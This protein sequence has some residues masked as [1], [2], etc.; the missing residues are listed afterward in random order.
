MAVQRQRVEEIQIFGQKRSDFVKLIQVHQSAGFEHQRRT[1]HGVVLLRA[2]D[3]VSGRTGH[4]RR[5]QHPGILFHSRGNGYVRI[6]LVE[7]LDGRPQMRHTHLGDGIDDGQRVALGQGVRQRDAIQAFAIRRKGIDQ[8]F[9]RL[10]AGNFLGEAGGNGGGAALADA[11]QANLA[12]GGK[13]V[14]VIRLVA[15]DDGHG[16]GIQGRS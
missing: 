8:A 5:G 4:H 10:Q 7:Q 9:V 3:V 14:N 2:Q 13:Q 12:P 11:H 6:P 16:D 1:G 15:V